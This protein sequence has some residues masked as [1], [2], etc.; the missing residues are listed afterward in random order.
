MFVQLDWNK[1]TN[2]LKTVFLVVAVESLCEC[3]CDKKKPFFRENYG[4]YLIATFQ[5]GFSDSLYF[6]LFY[7]KWV[8]KC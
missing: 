6:S 8:V 4:F 3:V 2:Y 1:I 7:R 5:V